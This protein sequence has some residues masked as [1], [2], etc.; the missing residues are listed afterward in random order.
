M[1]HIAI[2]TRED[3]SDRLR[4]GLRLGSSASPS[5]KSR[6]PVVAVSNPRTP[7]PAA[8]STGAKPPT[9]PPAPTPPTDAGGSGGNKSSGHNPF[10]KV[11]RWVSSSSPSSHLSPGGPVVSSVSSPLSSSPS[12]FPTPSSASPKRETTPL[13]AIIE[14]NAQKPKPHLSFSSFV[15]P[16]LFGAA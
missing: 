1:Q 12:T 14:S 6:N 13:Q 15:P 9:A 2:L 5:P 8:K 7:A 10:S 3:L 4:A 11:D 16:P